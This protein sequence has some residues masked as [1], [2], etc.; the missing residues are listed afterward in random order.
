MHTDIQSVEVLQ[1]NALDNQLVPAN[2]I[3]KVEGF[4]GNDSLSDSAGNESL[5]GGL[6]DDTLYSTAGS[7]NLFGE[8]GNDTFFISSSMASAYGGEGNDTFYL[9]SS[10]NLID[11]GAGQNS[12]ELQN[13]AFADIKASIN[14]QSLVGNALPNTLKHSL[15]VSQKLTTSAQ[16]HISLGAGIDRFL[17]GVIADDRQGLTYSLNYQ[18]DTITLQT[19]QFTYHLKNDVE[20]I[21]FEQIKQGYIAKFLLNLKT[22]KM[23]VISEQPV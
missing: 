8:Q 7:D 21:L 12:I 11:G 19:G 23:T 14:V 22:Q 15:S 4:A 3:E 1:G 2:G 5:Y 16:M 10:V 18:A 9:S 13:V 6:G 20:F 17:P